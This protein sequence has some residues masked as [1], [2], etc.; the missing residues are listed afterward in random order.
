MIE[1][2]PIPPPWPEL[3]HLHFGDPLVYIMAGSGA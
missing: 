2:P 1:G 3:A